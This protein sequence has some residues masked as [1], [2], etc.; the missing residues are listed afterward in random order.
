LLASF[1]S[2]RLILDRL[3]GEIGEGKEN[4]FL[5]EFLKGDG[6]VLGHSSYRVF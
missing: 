1:E 4:P 2:I 3:P 6:H 5:R